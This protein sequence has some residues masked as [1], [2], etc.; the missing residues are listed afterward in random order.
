LLR[1]N[2]RKGDVHNVSAGQAFIGETGSGE[3]SGKGR[4]QG[5]SRTICNVAYEGEGSDGVRSG[6]ESVVD[7][8]KNSGYAPET[9]EN[10]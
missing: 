4:I 2:E 9:S 10:R 8:G 7:V 6:T 3:L 5:G 1:E